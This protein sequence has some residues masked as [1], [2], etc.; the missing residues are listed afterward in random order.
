MTVY[1]HLQ[2]NSQ[3]NNSGGS[4][5]AHSYPG[6]YLAS[7]PVVISKV[8]WAI[9]GNTWPQY[10]AQQASI[11]A[12][13]VPGSLNVI[14]IRPNQMTD[15]DFSSLYSNSVA[16]WAADVTAVLQTYLNAGMRICLVTSMLGAP[17]SRRHL[18]DDLIASWRGTYCHGVADMRKDPVIQDDAG[19]YAANTTYFN[20]PDGHLTDAGQ[21]LVYSYF[22]PAMNDVVRPSFFSRA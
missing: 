12:A 7:P 9:N 15:A 14:S 18:Q 1:W 6:L 22:Q 4:D 8:H 17:P 10:K 11:L 13:I 16:N 5:A 19:G 20:N 21:A 2:G 3:E